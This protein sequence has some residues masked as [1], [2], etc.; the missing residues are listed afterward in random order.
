MQIYIK[1]MNEL[2][3]LIVLFAV[4]FDPLASLALF[5]RAS[6]NEK[7]VNMLAL[8]AVAVAAVLSFGVL[9]FGERLLGLFSTTISEFRIGGGII[10]LLLGIKM[11]LGAPLANMDGIEGNSSR[12][13]AAIIGT[14]LLT[15]PAA[16]TAIIVARADFG[17][18]STGLAIAIV[19]A[20]TA[21][22]FIQA[23]HLARRKTFVQISSTFLGLVTISW[24]VK[25]IITGLKAMF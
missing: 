14:P 17:I 8:Y 21:L 25:F 2:I 24:G 18:L 3:Q 1:I 19:L 12:A 13:I 11:S 10:L 9:L 5:I 23:K 22:L 6:A 20:G 7:N 16:I 15:G 4:I